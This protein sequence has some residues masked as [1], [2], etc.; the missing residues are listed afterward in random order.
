MI[1]SRPHK[2]QPGRRKFPES[3]EE[4]FKGIKKPSKVEAI[5]WCRCRGENHRVALIN[6]KIV[7]PEHNLFRELAYLDFG[8]LP[9]GCMKI[10]LAIQQKTTSVLTPEF[11]PAL[12]TMQNKSIIRVKR[13]TSPIKHPDTAKL[14]TLLL[15]HRCDYF[16]DIYQTVGESITIEP[17]VDVAVRN[18]SRVLSAWSYTKEIGSQRRFFASIYVSND[19]K[20]EIYDRGV[21]VVDRFLVLEDLGQNTPNQRS[22]IILIWHKERQRLEQKVAVIQKA[23]GQWSLISMEGY[24]RR[25]DTDFDF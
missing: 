21:A 11:D 19:W 24:A 23:H 7:L 20:K 12:R 2:K 3:K 10:Y 5:L 17:M 1:F 22:V 13:V 25:G 15:K 16:N 4:L 6:G 9:C 18:S 8:A 14:I